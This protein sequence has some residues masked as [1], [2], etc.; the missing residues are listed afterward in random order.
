MPPATPNASC[1][2][3]AIF[4]RSFQLSSGSVEIRDVRAGGHGGRICLQAVVRLEA[5][6]AHR[7]SQKKPLTPAGGAVRAG[8]VHIGGGR[9]QITDASATEE[10]GADCGSAALVGAV[11]GETFRAGCDCLECPRHQFFCNS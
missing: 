7:N 3:G 8:K 4:S 11:L 5:L 10:G 2:P 6:A 9:L 1:T